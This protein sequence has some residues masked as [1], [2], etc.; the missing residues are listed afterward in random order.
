MREET[1]PIKRCQWNFGNTKA[2]ECVVIDLLGLRKWN[3]KPTRRKSKKKPAKSRRQPLKSHKFGALELWSQESWFKVYLRSR[4]HRSPTLPHSAAQLSLLQRDGR[5]ARWA[6]EPEVLS[7]HRHKV[8]LRNW[9]QL[10]EQGIVWESY[11]SFPLLLKECC[12]L[13]YISPG[14]IREDSLI[15]TLMCVCVYTCIHVD[16]VLTICYTLNIIQLNFYL[17]TD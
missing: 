3:Y 2:N 10:Q 13:A 9:G 15:E 5:F 6:V 4:N 16:Y 7:T 11:P 17:W 14:G 12:Q 1:P 8:S